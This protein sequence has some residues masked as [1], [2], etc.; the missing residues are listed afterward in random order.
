MLC[1]GRDEQS[2]ILGHVSCLDCLHHGCLEIQC[3]LDEC[4]IAIELSAV[5]QSACPCKDG[6]HGVGAGGIA[7]LV[8]PPVAGHS[9]VRSFCLHD[10]AIRSDEHR[11][12]QAQGTKALCHCVALHIAIIVLQSPNKFAAALQALCHH[13][14]N[15]AVLIPDLGLSK[16]C[17]VACLVHLGKD[18]QKPAII[19]LE[20]GVLGGEVQ[21]PLLG[22]RVLKARGGKAPDTFVHVVHAHCH[23][24]TVEVVHLIRHRGTAAAGSVGHLHLAWSGHHK[25]SCTILITKSM[26]ANHDRI[27]PTR[28]QARNVGDH[29]GL[30]EHGAVEDVTDGAIWGLPHLFQTELHDACLIRGDSGALDAHL[31][32]LDGMGGVC[33]DFVVSRIPIFHAQ[34]VVLNLQIEVRQ[35][36]LVLDHGP[37]HPGHLIPIKINHRVGDLDFDDVH[38]ACG[39]QTL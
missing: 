21:R 16:L 17:L 30:S 32:F 4:F 28:H 20:N 25:V 33:C 22:Q 13:V 39:V 34:I 9:A 7:L 31:V 3:P 24:W 11:G 23:T 10:L 18:L 29:N 2:Q 5:R 36:E 38:V 15:Q 6:C 26:P 8:L 35:N 1:G 27:S 37:D 12:H 14:V 19:C